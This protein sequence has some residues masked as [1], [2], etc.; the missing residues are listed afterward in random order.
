[1]L[2]QFN[3]FSSLL[4]IF[5]VHG[6]VYAI[7]LYRKSIINESRSDKWLGFFLLICALYI[8]PWMVGFA[9]WYDTQPYRDILFYVPFQHLFFIGPVIFFYVQSLLNPSFRFG[10]KEWLHLI[11]GLLYL[12]FH[13]VMVVT[14]KLVLKDYYFLINGQDPDFDTWYQLTGFS[15]M[16]IYFLLS[17]RYYRLYKKLIVQV[18]SYAELVMFR[19][20]QNFLLAFL[21]MLTVRLGFYISD[22]FIGSTYASNWWHFFVFAVIFYYIAITGYANSIETK[23]AFH[24]NLLTY[25]PA[26]LLNY[27]PSLI[28]VN[29]LTEE[30][31]EIDIDTIP[32]TNNNETADIKEW[33]EKL[34]QL[35]QSGKAYED[36]ELS[37]AQ[38]AKQLQSNPSF[39]SRMVNQGFQ[40]NFNDFV[41]QFRIEAVKEMLNRGDH[42]KQ[43]LLGIAL[44]CGFNS[45][46]T[47]NRA[48]K[49]STGQ[50]PKAYISAINQSLPDS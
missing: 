39:I 49:K 41:N 10:K 25:R 46:A 9:G 26:L 23:I 28:N 48:F 42:K 34:L 24:P 8:V 45:K 32:V 3:R 18:I 47:F 43:T 27:H 6:L 21:L 37:L 14:D 38:V 16:L 2:F 11:P 15:S 13:I 30:E 22:F 44:D 35:M 40:Q 50:S 5:F 17:L 4:L 29:P 36:P 1:M 31:A 33:K 7:L 12:A 20:I 19:W